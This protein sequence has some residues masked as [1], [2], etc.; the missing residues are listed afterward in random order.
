MSKVFINKSRIGELTNFTDDEDPY[1][2][3]KYFDLKLDTS[4]KSISQWIDEIIQ[5][6]V[7]NEVIEFI[8]TQFGFNYIDEHLKDY[9]HNLKSI[10]I[11]EKTLKLLIQ[12]KFLNR[13]Y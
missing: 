2:E 4:K 8:D 12:L 11:D 10:Q 3:P 9:S 6:L 5:L 7:D 1:E 13:I